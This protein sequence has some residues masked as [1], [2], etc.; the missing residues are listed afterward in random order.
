VTGA[1][2]DAMAEEHD[3]LQQHQT[4]TWEEITMRNLVR[5]SVDKLLGQ[6]DHSFDFPA[7][8]EFKII[9][10]PN[11]IGK[12]KL[13]E[14]INATLGGNP[15]QIASIPFASAS[16]E[17]DDSS[18]LDIVQHAE[19]PA[20]MAESDDETPSARGILFRLTDA[21]GKTTEQYGPTLKGPQLRRLRSALEHEFPLNRV[22]VDSWY[23]ISSNTTLSTIEALNRYSTAI[24]SRLGLIV[25]DLWP[26]DNPIRQFLN[27][28]RIYF[29]ETQRLLSDD[30]R[31]RQDRYADRYGTS[32]STVLELADDLVNRLK[33]AL[34]QNA[35]TSQQL[36]RDFPRRIMLEHSELPEATDKNIQRRYNEQ[37]SLRQAL[38]ENALLEMPGYLPL[39][40]R[41]LEGWERRVLWTYLAD[42]ERKLETF[43]P[44]LEKTQLLTEIVNSRFLF[45][46]LAIDASKGLKF[47]T[48][49][50]AEISPSLL[51]S[52]EQHELVLAYKLLFQAEENSLVLID[53]PEI[54]LHVA[55]QRA[56]LDDI[57]RIAKV[58]SLRFIIATHSP[59]IINKW[60]SRTEALHPDYDESR[61]ESE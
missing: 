30:R 18:K 6:F 35:R 59:Q 36:D 40:Q 45:K 19:I 60:W 10:G 16:F 41:P 31:I 13:L 5:V 38:A 53:E 61:I 52:G 33:D 20:V 47:V 39:P 25:A 46:A 11:G 57:I 29:I 26:E 56:F 44:I 34:A 7:A 42:T 32:R 23:D 2:Q 8:D 55:W 27:D 54:S 37:S 43:I 28:L 12:T 50:G 21:D 3:R 24:E 49:A 48:N 4:A 17:F 9:H 58:S 22:G 51:S 14:L 1:G 15:F